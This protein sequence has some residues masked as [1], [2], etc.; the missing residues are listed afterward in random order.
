MCVAAVHGDYLYI[1][2]LSVL[3]LEF[4]RPT[5][6]KGHNGHSFNS[7]KCHVSGYGPV[8][9]ES[10]LYHQPSLPSQVHLSHVL[11]HVILC[12]R[13]F[14][15]LTK[16]RTAY[17]NLF[18]TRQACSSHHPLLFGFASDSICQTDYYITEYFG[19]LT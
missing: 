18:W 12:E 5:E 10:I 4:K 3:V 2:K 13:I 15:D 14:S 8:L 9:L 7:T 19:P 16:V 1:E 17:C 6:K 11:C